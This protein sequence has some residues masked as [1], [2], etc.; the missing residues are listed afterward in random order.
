MMRWEMDVETWREASP[1][2]SFDEL[3]HCY[4]EGMVEKVLV[5]W[6]M[7]VETWHEASL[8]VFFDELHHCTSKGGT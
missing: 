6:E 8:Q 1:Q 7:D 5:R 3:H 2:A 4:W